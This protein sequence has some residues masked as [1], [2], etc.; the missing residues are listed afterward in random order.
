MKRLVA[1]FVV[2]SALACGST[3]EPAPSCTAVLPSCP[4]SG[5]PGYR[6]TVAPLIASTCL[7]CHA[8]GGEQS[9]RSFDTYTKLHTQRSPALNQI[10]ACT[11]PPVDGPRLSDADRT[12]LMT[13]FVCGAPD[14]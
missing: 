2:A 1:A 6:T 8:P 14:N 12:T 11:M 10:H 9:S 3:E 13:W 7:S 4:S 5:A